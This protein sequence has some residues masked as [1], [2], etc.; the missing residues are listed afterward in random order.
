MLQ[1]VVRCEEALVALISISAILTMAI[2]QLESSRHKTTNDVVTLINQ[3]L[4]CEI[5]TTNPLAAG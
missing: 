4:F 5:L 2:E 1:L 3:A